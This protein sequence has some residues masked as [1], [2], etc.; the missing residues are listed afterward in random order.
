MTNGSISPSKKTNFARRYGWPLFTLVSSVVIAVGVLSACSS[1]A[2]PGATTE[3]VHD[4]PS[5]NVVQLDTNDD[6]TAEARVYVVERDISLEDGR[7]VTCLIGFPYRTSQAGSTMSC[8]W[9]N[10]G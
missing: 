2:P 7:S 6:G 10:A 8:D 4:L 3:S 9:E 5:E 1:T